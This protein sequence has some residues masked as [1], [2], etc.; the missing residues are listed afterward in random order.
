MVSSCSLVELVA[1]SR[2]RLSSVN[3][4][5]STLDVVCNT[6]FSVPWFLC[7]QQTDLQEDLKDHTAAVEME[8]MC[9]KEAL[10]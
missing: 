6:S 10:E 8:G 7:Q 2:Q 3:R 5:F 9:C 4:S 1:V